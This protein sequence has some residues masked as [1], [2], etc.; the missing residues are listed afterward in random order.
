MKKKQVSNKKK[1]LKFSGII[2]AIL[3]LVIT[4]GPLLIPINGATGLQEARELMS[5]DGQMIT[6]PFQG[7]DGI[8]TYYSYTPAK[9]DTDKTFILLH[10]SLYSNNTW[11]EITDYL[12]TKGNVYAYDQAP[13]GLSEKLI[14]GDWTKDNPYTVN[15]AIKQLETFMDVLEI[16]SATL[17]G[18]SY[19]GVLAAEAAVKMPQRVDNLIFVDPA[20][21]IN[22]SMP[23]WF[24]ELPQME[25]LGPIFAR[26]LAEGDSFYES[27]YYDKSK[28]TD[29]R[30]KMNK[31]LTQVKNWDLAFWEYLQ[32]WR[33]NPSNVAQK[34][35]S[36]NQNS[37]VIS[38]E[39][40]AIVPLEQS[41][42]LARE[43]PNSTL[44]IIEDCGH[45]PH[46]EKPE[47]FIKTLDS[48]LK[49]Q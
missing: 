26:F 19:G 4:I 20:I 2:L 31:Q 7:T 43:L 30:T 11:N 6:L 3:V 9:I 23:K 34:V 40:D 29:Q 25:R 12:S 44:K 32:A 42:Q 36:I 21:Y 16:E 13:Y 15:A 14:E 27:T 49:N 18:S 37:L 33:A 45:L 48:W 41:Q 5:S 1:W 28:I 38:G 10:G 8:E 17:M 35:R 22:E 39:Q 46:E 24:L 47:V